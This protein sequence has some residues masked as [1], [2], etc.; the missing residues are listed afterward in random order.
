[1]E[2]VCLQDLDCLLTQAI[3]IRRESMRRAKHFA[4]KRFSIASNVGGLIT[5]V[6]QPDYPA[7]RLPS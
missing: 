3:R 4:D 7:A 2:H 6:D 5:H 1:M